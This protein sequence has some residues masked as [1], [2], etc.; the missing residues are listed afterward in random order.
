MK[1]YL[2]HRVNTQAQQ[3]TYSLWWCVGSQILSGHALQPQKMSGWEMLTSRWK[4]LE[5]RDIGMYRCY[6][7][8]NVIA[9]E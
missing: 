8:F 2:S 1:T 5:E 3:K 7:Q 4:Q 6:L 9:L